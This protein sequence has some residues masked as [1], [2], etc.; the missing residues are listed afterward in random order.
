MNVLFLTMVNIK[1]VHSEGI[2]EDL[3][4]EFI[5]NG[6]Q[7]FIATPTEKRFGENTQVIKEENCEI[8]RIRTGNLQ[9]TSFIKKGIA[10]LKITPLFKKSIKKYF[11]NIKFDLILYSTPPITLYGVI[12]YLKK[13]DNAKTFLL[14]KDI[15]PQNAVDID[16]LKMSGIKGII[17]RYFRK[18]EKKLYTISDKIG[19]M[20]QA[21]VSYIAKHNP[22]IDKSKLTIVPNSIE[23]IDV[24]L[25]E[26]E[27]TQMREKYGIPQD[28]IIFVYGG[29]LGKPQGIPFVSDCLRSQ[30]NKEKTFFLIVG[31]GTEYEL[32]ENFVNTYKPQNVN[33]LKRLPREDFDRLLSACDVGMVFLDHRFTIPNY[34][35]RILSYMQAGLPVL[36]CTDPNTDVGNDIISGGFGWQCESKNLEQFDSAIKQCINSDLR[37]MGK[38]ASLYLRDNFTVKDGYKKIMNNL[39]AGE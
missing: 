24:S 14:L 35:S 9:K 4:R 15:F 25:T 36:A 5:K 13:R 11:K 19:C 22:E 17:Y 27:K 6:H 2:Y 29:N 33:L 30:A 10:T 26:K 8:L 39:G 34:P 32:L 3:L 1:S 23:P 28:R 20:S 12:K 7:I 16:I 18:K 31:D 37:E 21:N 38:R